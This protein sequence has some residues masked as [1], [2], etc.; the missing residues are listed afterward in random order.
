MTFFC[1]ALSRE[2]RNTVSCFLFSCETEV[3]GKQSAC[4]TQILLQPT[5]CI[6][7]VGFTNEQSR[8]LLGPRIARQDLKI[9]YLWLHVGGWHWEILT[10][11]ICY[12]PRKVSLLKTQSRLFETSHFHLRSKSCIGLGPCPGKGTFQP[13]QHVVKSDC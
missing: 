2:P 3:T 13:K 10:Q 6:S 8:L 1:A 9:C 12:F 4:P 7:I 5:S 11:R